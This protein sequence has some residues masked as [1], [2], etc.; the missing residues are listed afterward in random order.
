MCLKSINN[1]LNP[2]SSLV[3]QNQLQYFKTPTSTL[4]PAGIQVQ[5]LKAE[6]ILCKHLHLLKAD[7]RRFPQKMKETYQQDPVAGAAG[8]RQEHLS[9][10]GNTNTRASKAV[11][12]QRRH[13]RK[14]VW[15]CPARVLPRPFNVIP[16]PSKR[17][18]IYETSFIP[19][20]FHSQDIFLCV[21]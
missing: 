12:W 6:G 14:C 2:F 20:N 11:G 10:N 1:I 3:F 8:W 16:P 21:K 17:K 5:E 7:S 4:T 15:L 13:L 9:P 19:Q 18:A